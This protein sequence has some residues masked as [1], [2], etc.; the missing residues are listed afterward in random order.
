MNNNNITYNN[1]KN[2]NK[3]QL[4]MTLFGPSFKARFVHQQQQQQQKQQHNPEKQQQQQLSWVVTAVKP[5]FEVK[6][7]HGN[8][9]SVEC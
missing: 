6:P 2:N 4:S 1:N 7:E 8:N 3:S 9:I 5:F